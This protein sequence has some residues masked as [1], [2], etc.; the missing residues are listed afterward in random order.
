MSVQEP[1]RFKAELQ[2]HGKTATGITVPDAIVEQL[3]AGKRPPVVVTIKG[4]S[5]RTTVAPMGGQ[6]LIPVAAEHREAA[7]ATA[8]EKVTVDIALDSAPREV[9]VPKDLAAALKKAGVRAAYDKLS[10]TSRKEM[11]RSLEDA[12]TDETRQRRLAKAIEKLQ[13]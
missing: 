11:V 4:Y 8:G 13:A 2:L 12:K 1:L 9:E 10:F 6:F 3:G 5:Y 7:D